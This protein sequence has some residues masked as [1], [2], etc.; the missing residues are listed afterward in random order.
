MILGINVFML[1]VMLHKNNQIVIQLTGCNSITTSHIITNTHARNGCIPY[2]KLN[3]ALT[4]TFL[5]FITALKTRQHFGLCSTS[6]MVM[7][8]LRDQRY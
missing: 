5:C 6:V 3:F 8:L 2:T 7:A 1:A 4:V